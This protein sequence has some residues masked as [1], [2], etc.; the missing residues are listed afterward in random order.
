M[1]IDPITIGKTIKQLRITQ[2]LS[3][4]VMSGFAGI[5]RSHLA[6]IENGSKQIT[7]QTLCKIA[8]ALEM[9]PSELVQQI[10]KNSRN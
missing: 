7:F 3:Q 4:D 8:Q 10:E 6:M 5:A 2:G 9:N 1:Q